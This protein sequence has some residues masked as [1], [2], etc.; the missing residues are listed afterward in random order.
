MATGNYFSIK[1]SAK[2]GDLIED[3]EYPNVMYL[4]HKWF[5]TSEDLAETFIDLYPFKVNFQDQYYFFIYFCLH[6]FLLSFYKEITGFFYFL[7]TIDIK[8][9]ITSFYNLLFSNKNDKF[10]KFKIF[11]ILCL[12]V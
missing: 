5:I 12:F 10:E 6:F 8:L 11:H 9:E 1:I 2:E 3:T 7:D 4:M